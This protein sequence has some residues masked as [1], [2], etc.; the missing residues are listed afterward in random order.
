MAVRVVDDVLHL[1]VGQ[2]AKAGEN[3]HEIGCVE[4]V[5]PGN[6]GLLFGIDFT[7]FWVDGEQ[8]RA[9]EAGVS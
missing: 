4:C 1:L 6:I 7:G 8:N 5:E 9:V 2:F 3:E